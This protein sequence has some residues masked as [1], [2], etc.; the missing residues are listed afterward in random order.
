VILFSTPRLIC[1][2]NEHLAHAFTAALTKLGEPY[3]MVQACSFGPNEHRAHLYKACGSSLQTDLTSAGD[4]TISAPD[5]H[6]KGILA[7]KFR[8]TYPMNKD[9]CMQGLSGIQ[10]TGCT[11]ESGNGSVEV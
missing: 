3:S 6:F 11:N 10:C 1:G 8:K 9:R 2:P 5:V 7:R 4:S